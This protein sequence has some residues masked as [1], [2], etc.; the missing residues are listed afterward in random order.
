MYTLPGRACHC[1]CACVSDGCTV[2]GRSD[3]T[4]CYACRRT[5]WHIMYTLSSRACFLCLRVY[6]NC[7]CSPEAATF[8]AA[9]ACAHHATACACC[10]SAQALVLPY[11]AGV[12]EQGEA[13]TG[14]LESS[15]PP[16]PL[17]IS[18]S[19]CVVPGALAMVMYAAQLAS[20]LLCAQEY[21]FLYTWK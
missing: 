6:D 13:S 18:S 16:T 20:L 17:S 7:T 11:L 14:R 3:Y 5:S 8:P 15:V 1:A 12:P 9:H 21:V 2:L 4:S 19:D 10:L